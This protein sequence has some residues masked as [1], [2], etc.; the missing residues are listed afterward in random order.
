MAKKKRKKSDAGSDDAGDSLGKVIDKYEVNLAAV[1]VVGG[2]IAAIGLGVA[3]Y[4]LIAEPTSLIALGIGTLLLLA[5]IVFLVLNLFNAGR[6]LEVRKRGLRYTEMGIE[7]EFLWDEIVD[8]SVNRTDE[9]NLGVATV[10]RKSSDS[11][12]PSGPLTKTEWDVTITSE[13]GRTMHLP[14]MFFK[15]VSDPKKLIN[16][17]RMRSGLK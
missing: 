13:S 7:T 9:T 11:L 3:G 15:I 4:G 10:G 8:V 1:L 6:K 14:A 16:Q 17:I 5:A 12:S 2:V